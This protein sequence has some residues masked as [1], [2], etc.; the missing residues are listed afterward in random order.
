M[1]GTQ[2]T[3]SKHP[4]IGPAAGRKRGC[5]PSFGGTAS[6]V[7]DS[8]PTDVSEDSEEGELTVFTLLCPTGPLQAAGEGTARVDP[9]P[10]IHP[11][12]KV[13]KLVHLTHSFFHSFLYSLI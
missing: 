10:L 12:P 3:L 7:G 9:R 6:T 2:G 11:K 1:P 13:G 4:G 5:G 8:L